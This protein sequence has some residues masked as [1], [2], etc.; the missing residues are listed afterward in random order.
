MNRRSFLQT[1]TASLAALGWVRPA[2]R[3]ELEPLF[4]VR[5]DWS[6]IQPT[7]EAEARNPYWQRQV[8]TDNRGAFDALQ[9]EMRRISAQCQREHD[10]RTLRG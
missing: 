6:D 3:Y 4:G 5:A 9:A 8:T 2:K 10:W 1:L 7:L